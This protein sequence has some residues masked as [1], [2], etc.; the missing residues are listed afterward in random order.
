M[1]ALAFN[2]LPFLVCLFKMFWCDALNLSPACGKNGYIHLITMPACFG[3]NT[4]TVF[5]GNR[6]VIHCGST[7]NQ[8][9]PC[10]ERWFLQRVHHHCLC[11]QQNLHNLWCWQPL[12]SYEMKV[13]LLLRS[14]WTLPCSHRTM[15]CIS[16]FVADITTNA[17][18]SI[19]LFAIPGVSVQNV[20]CL[21]NA[22]NLSPALGKNGFIP[23]CF[24]GTRGFILGQGLEPMSPLHGKMVSSENLPSLP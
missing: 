21:V 9:H 16:G 13:Y 4:S 19:Q 17:C 14:K 10:M 24:G 22:L 11:Q 15:A 6:G 12:T 7:L 1:P 20:F 23:V 5:S 2:S 8:C 18:F 3:S